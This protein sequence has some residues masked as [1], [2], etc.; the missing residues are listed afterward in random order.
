L[1]IATKYKKSVISLGKSTIFLYIFL[2]PFGA[3]NVIDGLTPYILFKVS[4]VLMFI[5]NIRHLFGA[6]RF[7]KRENI[8]IVGYFILYILNNW[9]NVQ[10]ANPDVFQDISIYFGFFDLFFFL[11]LL[12]YLIIQQFIKI[13]KESANLFIKAIMYSGFL[14]SLFFQ[15]GLFVE[16]DSFGRLTLFN[17]NSNNVGMHLAI[18][19]ILSMYYLVNS[20][21]NLFLSLILLV[22][23]LIVFI[24]IL[25]TGSRAALMSTISVI[26]FFINLKGGIIQK[27]SRFLIFIFIILILIKLISTQELIVNRMN[28]FFEDGDVSGRDVLFLSVLPYTFD[29]W[30]LGIG[31]SGYYSLTSQYFAEFFSPH[32]SFFEVFI[33]TGLIGFVIFWIWI[34]IILKYSLILKIR[35]SSNLY[36]SLAVPVLVVLLNSQFFFAKVIWVILAISVASYWNIAS[37]KVSSSEL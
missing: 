15:F 36:I 11:N 32:N 31:I 34:Y 37:Q 4:F 25:K 13:N 17:D 12:S 30:L 26:I 24:G 5:T 23:T 27:L 1:P 2:L 18:S 29:H 33:Y 10:N 3:F 6:L 35:Y 8:F 9:I 21:Q 7:L 14:V 16:I 22:L 19:F 20:R 28:D